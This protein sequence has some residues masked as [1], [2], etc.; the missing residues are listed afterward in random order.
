MTD[1]KKLNFDLNVAGIRIAQTYPQIC[2]HID[3]INRYNVK[4]F[5][6]VGMYMGGTLPYVISNLVLDAG[7]RYIGFDIVSDHLDR[8]LVKLCDNTKN[9]DIIIDDCF[10]NLEYIKE[11]IEYNGVTYIFCDGGDKPRELLTFSKLLKIGDLISVHD[12][13]ITSLSK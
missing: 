8:R 5:M 6:E 10:N 7:F 3:I 12:S 4:L 13:S 11:E 9:C 1:F 2:S